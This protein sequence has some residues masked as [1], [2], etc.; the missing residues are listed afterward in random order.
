M[1]SILVRLQTAL[2]DL[3]AKLGMAAR[4]ALNRPERIALASMRAVAGE[5]GVAAPTLMRLAQ[6]M[7]FEN[8]EGLRAAFQEAVLTGGFGARVAALSQP[9]GDDLAAAMVAAAQAN[10]AQ[11]LG[12][13]D[14]RVLHDMARAMI[15]ARHLEIVSAGAVLA[16]GEGM[17]ASGAMLLP[18]L[19]LARGGGVTG[20]E[21]LATTG[22]QDAVL[23]LTLAPYARRTLDAAQ[24]ARDA[25]AT[26]LAITDGRGAPI[27]QIADL[28]LFAPTQSQHY[29]PSM[30]ALQGL[31]ELVLATVAALSDT[32]ALAR[33]RHFDQLRAATGAY[34]S[35]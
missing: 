29:Y 24:A 27:T 15:A 13:V 5:V 23:V 14:R 8:Y 21:A 19:R 2:P 1:D 26:V 11:A 33:I 9:G 3:P 22:P 28:V 10:L 16:L 4:F 18:G 35:G 31:I 17:V 6:H 32:Q 30:V 20:A 7:G 34:I 25:G 12:G